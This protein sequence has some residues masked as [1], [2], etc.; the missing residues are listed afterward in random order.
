M[1]LSEAGPMRRCLV[2]FVA[3]LGCR[4]LAADPAATVDRIR[5]FPHDLVRVSVQG[6]P[7]VSVER[8]I[9]GDGQINVPLIGPV[10]IA[11]MTI[12]DAQQ[13]IAQHYVTEEI[14]IHPEVVL[15][16]V[17][18][19]PK[20][21]TVLGQVGKQGKIEFPPESTTLSIVDAIAS[22]GGMTRI[23]KGD[24]VRVTRHDPE[25]AEQNFTVDVNKM[26]DG[27]GGNG[28]TFMLQPGDVV[29]VPERVF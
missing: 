4:L 29:F 17:K 8:Q 28:S 10:K 25:G 13:A 9:D 24:A 18:H 16:V 19:A 2:L 23:A 7:D 26:V 27:R 21:V 14:F 11:G 3:I 1:L 20:E 12:A 15:S 22:A 5:L 6:E